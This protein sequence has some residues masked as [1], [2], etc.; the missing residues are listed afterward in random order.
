MT[1]RCPAHD[2]YPGRLRHVSYFLSPVTRGPYRKGNIDLV[3]CHFSEVPLHLE[4]STRCSLVLA[5]ASPP[6]R[7]GYFSLG[8]N[9]DYAASF[10]GRVPFFLEVTPSMPRTFGRNQLHISQ[11]ANQ[12]VEKVTDFLKEGQIVKVKVIETD[13]KGRIKLSMRALLEPGAQP[14]APNGQ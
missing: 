13:D 5:A 1:R 8:T 11:I 14:E 7:H 3:P 9:A 10:I 6:D 4:R 12:R 2:A